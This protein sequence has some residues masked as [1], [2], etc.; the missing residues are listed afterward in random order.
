MT[1]LPTDQKRKLLARLLQERGAQ[2]TA[3][4]VEGD[5]A[6]RSTSAGA[7]A[8]LPLRPI[9]RSGELEL[10]FGQERVWFVEQ[11]QPEVY[12]TT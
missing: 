3:K 8:A 12:F 10:S 7:A 9:D 11:L 1:D 4:R 6:G 5:K 2:Q